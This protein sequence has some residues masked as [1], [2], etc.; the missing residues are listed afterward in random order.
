MGKKIQNPVT[1]CAIHHLKSIYTA[2]MGPVYTLSCRKLE[3]LKIQ[4]A[5]TLDH[6]TFLMRW[7][8]Q[9]IL[10]KAF[11]IKTPFSGRRTSNIVQRA[12]Q[13]L[14]RDRIHFHW[15]NKDSQL[16]KVQE[17]GKFSQIISG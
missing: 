12:S 2:G 14:L 11:S 1:L 9:G 4:L 13:A 17:F 3:R 8:S 15:H 6:K 5:K 7:K 10:P 16:Q